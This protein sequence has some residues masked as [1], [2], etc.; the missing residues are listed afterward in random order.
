[1]S[2]ETYIESMY[3]HFARFD[4]DKNG[5]SMEEYLEVVNPQ[6]QA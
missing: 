5:V 4:I 1:M 2:E 3:S 6:N